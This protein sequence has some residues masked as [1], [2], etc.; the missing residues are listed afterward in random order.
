MY[1]R[2]QSTV[3][4][5]VRDRRRR[6]ARAQFER[7]WVDSGA[8][9]VAGRAR[10]VL[11]A[12]M[13]SKG[14]A[15]RDGGEKVEIYTDGSGGKEGATG[16]GWGLVAVKDG[17][18][19]HSACGPVLLGATGHGADRGTNNTGEITAVIEALRWLKTEAYGA[20]TI[21]YDSE[22][23]AKMAQGKWKAKV[24]RV[25][26]GNARR[27]Y[28]EVK[29]K[30]A[31]TWRWVKGH[32]GDRWNE[33]ADKLAEEGAAAAPPPDGRVRGSTEM[34]WS[35]KGGACDGPPTETLGQVPKDIRWIGV[36]RTEADRV[37]RRAT[38]RFGVLNMR[39]P[40]APA[41]KEEIYQRAKRVV[42]RLREEEAEGKTAGAVS[43]MAVR[44][45]MATARVLAGFG[46]EQ[47]RSIDE[48]QKSE[49][50]V[51]T[52]D[53]DI[54]TV[55]LRAAVKEAGDTGPVRTCLKQMRQILKTARA[56]KD[57]VVRY[58]VTYGHSELGRDLIEAGH[59]TGSRVSAR[60]PD[61]FKWETGLRT[62]AL[63]GA[64][65]FDDTA[66]Y[67]TARQAMT[68]GQ[69]GEAAHFLRHRKEILAM[70]GDIM[71]GRCALRREEK[72]ALVKRIATAYDMGAS[73]DFWRGEK[74]YGVAEIDTLSGKTVFVG[75]RS[76]SLEAYR[77]EL[78]ATAAWMAQR[79]A[80]MLEYLG[81]ADHRT[82]GKKGKQ[83]RR[84]AQPTLT[85]KSFV[86]QEAEA[87]GREAKIRAATA[88]GLRVVNLQHD[89]IVVRGVVEG[90][91]KEVARVMSE[92]VTAACGYEAGVTVERVR[93]VDR[94]D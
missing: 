4:K 19:V 38:T 46:V 39:V 12:P 34:D 43:D 18:E 9:E 67:S 44:K 50:A 1:G 81:Q 74:E 42:S 68:G 28:R 91:H 8:V 40:T 76:F 80:G 6:V 52:L 70:Y 47:K 49:E 79:A 64:W 54:D 93:H 86:L 31:V 5:M 24:N 94:V 55:R 51:H 59:V 21:V 88:L 90:R 36:G 83:K 37:L 87:V 57:G 61:P 2:I 82:R 11:T 3:Q 62:A 32:S 25:L 26:I 77:A 72:L 35:P 30:M 7:V 13:W 53:V 27:E 16:A 29:K 85:L 17:T 92:A 41:P 65:S 33:R 60:G 23:A 48:R 20:V 58:R 84:R 45:V 63:H 15:H 10:Q 22:Y 75:G 73:L 66:C 78:A 56:V 71:F 89:G 69:G 14:A